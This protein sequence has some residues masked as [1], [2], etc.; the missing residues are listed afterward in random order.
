MKISIKV[1]LGFFVIVLLAV[2]LSG[3]NF[4][5]GNKRMDLT[6][7]IKDVEAPLELMVEK[8]IGYDA[9]LTGNIH[10]AILYSQKE[11]LKDFETHRHNYNLIGEKLDNLLKNEAQDLLKK[12][13]RPIEIKNNVSEILKRLDVVNLALVDLETNAFAAIA[14]EDID[15]ASSFVTSEEYK[16]HKT[17]LA[18]LYNNWKH[19]ENE[20]TNDMRNEIINYSSK[21]NTINL[22]FTILIIIASIITSLLISFSISKPLKKLDENLQKISKGQINAPLEKSNIYE[23]QGLTESIGRLLAT[24]KLAILR[25]GATKGEL[26]LGEAIKARRLAEEELTESRE[27]SNTIL[28][29]VPALVFYKDKANNFIKVN[30]AFAEEMK[31]PVEKIEGTSV[32]KLY[33]KKQVDAFWKDDK[34]VITSGKP[35]TG[36]IEQMDTKTGTKWLRTDKIPYKN[37]NGEIIGVIGFS[38]D[39][40]QERI[41]E[42]KL[43][44]NEVRY[45]RLFEA[46]Q[47]AILILNAETGIIEDSNPFIQKLLGYSEKELK[48]KHLW[49]ISAFKDIVANKQ[50]FKEL[51]TKKFIRYEDMPL[52]TK[53]GKKA[54]VEFVSNLYLVDHTKVIQCNIRDITDRKKAEEALNRL[55]EAKELVR[56]AK[57]LDREKIAGKRE[58]VVGIRETKVTKREN[59]I[60]K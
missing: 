49:E 20:V 13:K 37:K 18:T 30:K 45:R 59:V 53:S 43:R 50:K 25:T 2:A 1:F 22:Y 32:N 35:K 40:T 9:M 47:D 55:K 60:K 15:L 16:A 3:I 58:S 8:V 31:I 38:V 14:Q 44:D 57:I 17:E 26:G 4:Y 54:Y 12:S 41:I 51:Q 48:G 19:I 33:P 21:L 6:N 46:A 10:E 39:I 24:V 34:Y 27:A 28:N 29:S 7:E 36:I 52:E 23:I 11:N 56:E 5:I 42:S